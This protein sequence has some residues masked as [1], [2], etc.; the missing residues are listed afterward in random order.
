[1]NTM[2]DSRINIVYFSNRKTTVNYYIRSAQYM[3]M[4]REKGRVLTLSYDK[5]PHTHRL[6]KKQRDNTKT[7][8]KLRLHNDCGPTYDGQFE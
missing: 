5:S 4:Q 7:P 1:M 3:Q 2:V 6:T 8:P